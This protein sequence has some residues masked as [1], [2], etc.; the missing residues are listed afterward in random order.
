MLTLSNIAHY[1][2]TIYFW[3]TLAEKYF[4]FAILEFLIFSESLTVQ[5]SRI[6]SCSGINTSGC[7]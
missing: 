1:N 4:L 3:N 2:D 5:Q 7:V 6:A